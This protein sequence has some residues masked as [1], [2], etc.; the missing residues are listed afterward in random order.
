MLLCQCSG[1]RYHGN[2][3]YAKE[4]FKLRTSTGM[5]NTKSTV[6]I[7]LGI[8][9]LNEDK[10]LSSKVITW[11]IAANAIG[12]SLH[13]RCLGKVF[14]SPALVTWLSVLTLAGF[15]GWFA[16]SGTDA[17]LQQI[18]SVSSS[19]ALAY[20][21][22]FWWYIWRALHWNNPSVLLP[23]KRS[24]SLFFFSFKTQLKIGF[25]FWICYLFLKSPTA[26][27]WSFPSFCSWLRA[28]LS[29]LLLPFHWYVLWSCFLFPV[30]QAFLALCSPLALQLVCHL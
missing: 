24:L 30:D 10:R 11:S 25:D 16:L 23:C 20:C 12:G 4:Y 2:Y 27:P 1:R 28:N 14:W 26:S 7:D 6:T 29:F 3:L 18:Y 19:T 13:P 21:L 15:A 9:S 8:I 22:V 5:I 17:V